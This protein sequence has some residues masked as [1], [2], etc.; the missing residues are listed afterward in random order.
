MNVYYRIL[1]G[2]VGRRIYHIHI[3]SKADAREWH[4]EQKYIKDLAE[5]TSQEEIELW[6]ASEKRDV[7][8]PSANFFEAI[9]RK[10]VADLI[11]EAYSKL[12]AAYYLYQQ[13]K[14]E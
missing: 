9:G 13:G 8:Y 2:Y 3:M 10:D 6:Y 7:N 11:R 14:N 1:F 4:R 5:E 12:E